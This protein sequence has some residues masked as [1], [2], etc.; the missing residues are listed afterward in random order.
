[1]DHKEMMEKVLEGLKS[2]G[3][4]V[5]KLETD[6]DGWG[7]RTEHAIIEINRVYLKIYWDRHSKC[8][9][10][11]H[12]SG[13][14]SP[15]RLEDYQIKLK[16]KAEDDHGHIY[17]VT[18]RKGDEGAWCLDIET[19]PG[20]WYMKTLMEQP[21]REKLSIYGDNWYCTNIAVVMREAMAALKLDVRPC[22][23][24]GR[25]FR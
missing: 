10:K 23:A 15:F 19:T 1:M 6:S 13:G 20:K 5:H 8:F 12:S 18:L 7:G 24:C 16:T 3:V 4:K 11:E 9:F 21:L 25:R 17:Q 14:S 22:E 2:E